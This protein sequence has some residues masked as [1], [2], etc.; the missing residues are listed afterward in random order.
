[1]FIVNHAF[2]RFE[3]YPTWFFVNF[4]VVHISLLLFFFFLCFL[5]LT[6]KLVR[7]FIMFT[8]RHLKLLAA[9][10][11]WICLW[12]LPLVWVHWKIM[13]SGI[14]WFLFCLF[15][16]F[17]FYLFSI[18]L[19]FA[20]S[21]Y[22]SSDCFTNVSYELKFERI[23]IGR[24]CARRSL[25]EMSMRRVENRMIMIRLLMLYLSMGKLEWMNIR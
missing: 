18:I 1:M 10:L 2:S 7:L 23:K 24:P 5:S 3:Y 14:I 25:K 4:W 16:L 9:L 8:V 15:I 20:S 6:W 17:L 12:F 19:V 11:L 22:F 21:S 13:R